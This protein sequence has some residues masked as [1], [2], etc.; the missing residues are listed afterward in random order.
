MKCGQASESSRH[1]NRCPLPVNPRVYTIA[2]D[3]H[4]CVEPFIR[5]QGPGRNIHWLDS[6]TP[7]LLPYMDARTHS[8]DSKDLA[9]YT[10]VRFSNLCS[11]NCLTLKTQGC[12]SQTWM[13]GHRTHSSN[14]REK[15]RIDLVQEKSGPPCVY[16]HKFWLNFVLG[17]EE[18]LKLASI[19]T[20]P[21]L[22][23]RH[24]LMMVHC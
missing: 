23:L 9:K 6:G 15:P 5:F 12:P 13:H 1:L 21:F 4:T 3:L 22:G 14:S 20:N 8:S 11:H 10:L 24:M 19:C 7:C 16:I 17:Q 18:F 2:T